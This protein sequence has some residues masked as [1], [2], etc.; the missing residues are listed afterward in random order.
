MRFF[1]FALL[2]VLTF[3]CNNPDVN[4]TQLIHYTP[5]NTSII[6][7]TDNI[8]SLKSSIKN[9]GFF[10]ILS[11]T[12]TFRNLETKL[13]HVSLL[14][15]TGDVL[16]CFSKDKTDSLQYTII[17]TFSKNLIITDSLKNYKEET[18]TYEDKSIIKA[19][20]KNH[21]FYSTVV[22][23]VFMAS[24][25]KDI[26]DS[27]YDKAFID[28]ELEKIYNT[29]ATDKTVS[30][31]INSKQSFIKS[32]FLDQGLPLK[33]FTNYTAVD[34]DINQ[35]QLFINGITKGLDSLNTINIFKN[36]IP[37]EN[38]LQN[39]T[40]NNS[41]GF[42]SFTFNDFENLKTNL[43]PFTKKDSVAN[44]T[45]LF[46]NIIEVGVIYEENKRAIVLNSLD[47]MATKDELLAELNTLET[48]RETDIFNFSNPDLFSK[49]FHPLITFNNATKYCVL[50]NF[51]VFA[52][53]IEL[54]HNI[55]ASYL[56]KTTLSEQSY[57]NDIKEQLNDASSLMLVG[58]PTILKTVLEKN[59][60]EP[61]G[62]G[63]S[64]YNA[65][66]LQFI[67]DTNFAHVNAII[68]QT[69][70][71]ASENSV[72]EE[73]NIKLDT[74]LL[75]TPQFVTNHITKEKEIV[76]QDINN[77]L[78]LIS[79]KGKI[80]WKKQ[81]EGPILGTMEQIDIY[82]NG[83]LQL[84]FATPHRVY[85]LDRNG[86]DVAPFPAKFNDNI[87]QPLSVFD[88]D[89]N[90][91]YRLLVTQG[92]NILMYDVNA[93]LV[94]GFTFKSANDNIINQPQHIRISGK[95]YITLKTQNKLYILDRTGRTR[96][97]PK[98][99]TTF[100]SEPVFFY[101][102]KFTTTNTTGDLI[103][104]DTNGNTSVLNLNLAEKHHIDA[105]SKTLATQSEN[106]LT[107]KGKT[108]EL[109]FGTYA[110]LKLFYINDKIYVSVT[111]LQAHKVYL[112]DSQGELLSNFPVYGNSIATLDTIDKNRT[113]GF[114]V[115]GE[116]NSV[117]L[118]KIY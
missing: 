98:T 70:I 4:R 24:S 10:E 43:Q 109:D 33:T 117:I 87:T 19:T 54:L 32:L 18:L 51:F 42:M 118:Y 30:I 57:F 104:I 31:I 56:N 11:N 72:S 80:L 52:D 58:N 110:P 28:T 27:A 59:L 55:I 15:P 92:K 93:K 40:P 107:I 114:A 41:D 39:I 63:L 37:Q 21:T 73:L 53:D 78:Y 89:K 60:E 25:S 7:R 81:L 29:T 48:F 103:S 86:K 76:V 17:T 49:T 83:R 14:K 84:T 20:L 85:V 106:R 3:S 94:S 6:L 65:S 35:N 8:E 46:D 47:I 101:N 108:V 79:N 100:S 99:S 22:D 90:K 16:I 26:I 75:N 67:Y 97:T 34:V 105:S 38:Q 74:D 44:S 23:S 9:S 50:D 113:L 45:T 1:C 66:A 96:I 5:E 69:K 112:Y 115:K 91:N 77:N 95:D 116:S 71:K 12:K 2:L 82:K 68:K 102:T 61:I 36:T 88:Y 62:S 13:E 111:D 64:N